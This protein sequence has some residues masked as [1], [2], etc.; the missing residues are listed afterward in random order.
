MYNIQRETRKINLKTY[1]DRLQTLNNQIQDSKSNDPE[2]NWDEELNRCADYDD[3]I[4]TC[5]AV[6][7]CISS[8]AISSN[9]EIAPSLLK[10]PRVPL[11][12]F[13]GMTMRILTNLL[14]NLSRL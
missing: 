6:L 8:N 4:C 5:L 13:I 11:P 7:D 3:R 9:S 10:A 14:E 12:K 2:F 1:S